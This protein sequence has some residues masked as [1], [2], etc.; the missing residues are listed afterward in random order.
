MRMI[1][2]SRISFT[3]RAALLFAVLALP[4]SLKAAEPLREWTV[5]FYSATANDL[6]PYTFRDVAKLTA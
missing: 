6:E 3:S 2:C 5:M 4:V 1:W